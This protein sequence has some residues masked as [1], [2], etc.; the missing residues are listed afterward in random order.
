M[1]KDSRKSHTQVNRHLRFNAAS[2]TEF[3]ADTACNA[4]LDAELG[5]GFDTESDAWSKDGAHAP[6]LWTD[7]SEGKGGR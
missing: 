1:N 5:A 7:K 4:R 6:V 3:D 2:D